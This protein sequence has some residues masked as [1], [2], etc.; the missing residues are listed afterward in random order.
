MLNAI[1]WLLR[2]GAPWRDL[3]E[4]Y[5]PWQTVYKWSSQWRRDGTWDKMLEALQIGLDSE[6]RIDWDL[7]CV[8]GTK[9][10]ARVPSSSLASWTLAGATTSLNGPPSA[11]SR[12]LRF[13]PA[14]ARS[15]GFGPTV[16][17]PKSLAH[18][19]VGGLPLP[20]HLAQ[21]VALLDDVCPDGLQHPAHQPSLVGALHGAVVAELFGQHVPLAAGVQPEDH[22]VQHGPR[23]GARTAGLGRRV[24]FF[25]D[26][27]D[28]FSQLVRH[29][30]N[31][32]QRLGL[33][34]SLARS[35]FLRQRV[36]QMVIGRNWF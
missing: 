12:M 30:P 29:A 26:V 14:L 9:M 13:T 7:S 34:V 16:S 28:P 35:Q 10:A 27:G 31:R 1:F 6:G 33:L 17:P 5:G 36:L 21:F 8:D 3:P 19:G 23:L 18:S 4:R 32:R 11:S 24:E 22:T 2:T 20:V 25:D 15:V